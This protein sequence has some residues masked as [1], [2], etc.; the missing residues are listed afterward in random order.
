MLDEEDHVTRGRRA[1]QLAS[2]R[3][4]VNLDLKQADD[5]RSIFLESFPEVREHIE[6]D[7]GQAIADNLGCTLAEVEAYIESDCLPFLGNL[8]RGQAEDF[9]DEQ[10]EETMSRGLQGSGREMLASVLE[11]SYSSP[12]R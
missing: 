7:G 8:L 3:F 1:R 11:Q 10:F 4:D 12:L 2:R 6:S 5:L 9:D